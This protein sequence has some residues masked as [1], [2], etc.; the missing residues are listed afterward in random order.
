M[1]DQQIQAWL[2]DLARLDGD[3]V[4]EEMEEQARRE[5][6]PMVGPQVGRLLFQLARL[7]GARHI[8]EMGS[9]FGYSTLWL[10]RG[11]GPGARIHHTDGSGERSRQAR[12]YLRR[13]GVADQIDF[14]V[15][16]AREVLQRTPGEMDLIF[17]DIDKHQY[18]SAYELL[19][20]RVRPGG[21]VVVDNL[22]W[23]GRVAAGDG[24]PDTEGVREYLR[25]MWQD[26]EYL[27]SLMPVRDGV[28]ISLR[29][30]G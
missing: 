17:M 18:P 7:T 26:P 8:F 23:D 14:H 10:T 3:P 12:E 28:G 13:A 21:L 22:V 6:F 20:E 5:D 4:I 29:L 15:G 9:G 11:A 1:S 2:Q 25:R 30:G 24:D 16:D 27:S 19:R